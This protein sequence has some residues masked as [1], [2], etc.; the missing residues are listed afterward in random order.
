[1][2]IEDSIRFRPY[3]QSNDQ[4][5]VFSTWLKNYRHSSYFA[6]RI[7]SSIFFPGHQKVLE[8]LFE[9]P[10]LRVVVATPIDD[11]QTIL[12]YLAAEFHHTKPVI[13]FIFIKDAF[14]NMGIAKALVN[15]VK[16]DLNEVQFTHWTI[17]VDD[18]IR[19]YPNMLYNPY[20]L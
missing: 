12:G 3:I 10:T 8:L 4:A 14:R 1:M 15:F 11:D 2:Q 7:R 16:I 19:K 20:C 13:H 5:F 17:P 6:K 18:Y 9:K